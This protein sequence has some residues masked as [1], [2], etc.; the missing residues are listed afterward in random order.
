[1]PKELK[2]KSSSVGEA[3]Q[4][5]ELIKSEFKTEYLIDEKNKEWCS[6]TLTPKEIKHFILAIKNQYYFQLYLDDL[7]MFSYVGAVDDNSNPT[8]SYY[9]FTHY[10][11]TVGHD[12]KGRIV[13]VNVTSDHKPVL[14]KDD[15]KEMEIK[16]TYTVEYIEDNNIVFEKRF[17]KYLDD[18]FFEHRIHWFSIFNSFMMVI[19]LSGLVFMI[20]IRT[21]RKDLLRYNTKDDDE[22]NPD[23][24]E[25]LDESGK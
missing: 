18:T 15:D 23:D 3:L 5:M 14:L 24:S 11:F 17:H 20:L 7:P 12:N 9:L 2:Y 1:M 21:L 13:E 19:F 8:P 10:L 16:F 4:G 25:F 6:K 22:L